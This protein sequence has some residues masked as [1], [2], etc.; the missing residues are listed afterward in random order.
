MNE[1]HI[2]PLAETENFMVY[3][4]TNEEDGEVIYHIEVFN[5]TVHFYKEEWEEFAALI[6][7]IPLSDEE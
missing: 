5:F 7:A 2:E 1:H 6:H 4:T 3:T